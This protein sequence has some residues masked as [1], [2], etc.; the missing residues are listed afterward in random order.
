[1]LVSFIFF[2]LINSIDCLTCIQSTKKFFVLNLFNEVEFKNTIN[3]F[4]NQPAIKKKCHVQLT[5]DYTNNRFNVEFRKESPTGDNI[6]KIET[7]FLSVDQPLI[8][9]NVTMIIIYI[10]SEI[11]DCNR[12]YVFKHFSS[13][14]PMNYNETQEKLFQLLSVE[15][16]GKF[17]CHFN[18]KPNATCPIKLN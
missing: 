17:S 3:N 11:D 1:M 10:C 5:I 7:T 13:M 2:C 18:L 16:K 15:Q 14:I 4:N 8:D 12:Q 9:Q 6:I